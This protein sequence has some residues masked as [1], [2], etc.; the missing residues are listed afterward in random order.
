M[1]S[2]LSWDIIVLAVACYVAAITLVRLMRRERD[3]VLQDL[4]HQVEDEKRRQGA[5]KRKAE[6]ERR[7]GEKRSRRSA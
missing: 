4:Q 1:E 6:R 5:E 3:E 7:P 2:F